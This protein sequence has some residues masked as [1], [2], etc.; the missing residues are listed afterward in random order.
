MKVMSLGLDDHKTAIVLLGSS[1]AIYII[2]VT[3]EIITFKFDIKF[4]GAMIESRF[5][6]MNM[7]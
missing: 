4:L 6:F 2:K 5:N 1:K 3:T 7:P